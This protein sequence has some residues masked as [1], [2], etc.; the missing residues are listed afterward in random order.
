MINRL[1]TIGTENLLVFTSGTENH[2]DSSDTMDVLFR[3]V[4]T[5]WFETTVVET[6]GFFMY[7]CCR[8]DVSMAFYGQKVDAPFHHK[9]RPFWT[10]PVAQNFY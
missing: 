5:R 4:T 1:S 2:A 8:T 7:P 6:T 3:Y 9:N 10:R